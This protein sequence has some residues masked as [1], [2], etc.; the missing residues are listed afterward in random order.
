MRHRLAQ[1]SCISSGNVEPVECQAAC[2]EK[3]RDNAK[4]RAPPTRPP[5]KIFNEK[6]CYEKVPSHRA[7]AWWRSDVALFFLI[8]LETPNHEIQAVTATFRVIRSNFTRTRFNFQSRR[9]IVSSKVVQ[10][11]GE[12]KLNI[13]KWKRRG[14][15]TIFLTWYSTSTSKIRQRE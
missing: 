5:V 8:A 6:R 2:P 1:K 3:R 10:F 13:V 12:L 4:Q 9:K 14:D 7:S 11:F 15:W